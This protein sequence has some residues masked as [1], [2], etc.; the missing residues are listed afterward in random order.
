[1]RKIMTLIAIA[2]LLTACKQEPASSK[3]FHYKN[4]D[5]EIIIGGGQVAKPKTRVDSS[6]AAYH[7]GNSL[8]VFNSKVFIVYT[9]TS[10]AVPIDNENLKKVDT[11][12]KTYYVPQIDTLFNDQVK[13]D[14]PLI[15]ANKKVKKGVLWF[16]I[17]QKFILQDY[18]SK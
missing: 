10:I 2:I 11:T 8:E 9:D 7:L 3:N 16:P 14:K 6:Y 4:G 18:K 1:M 15:D 12:I 17:D 13:R 5:S